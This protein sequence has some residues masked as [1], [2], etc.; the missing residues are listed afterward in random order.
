M[1]SSLVSIL[2]RFKVFAENPLPPPLPP[3]AETAFIDR[4][5]PPLAKM[6]PR[7]LRINVNQKAPT[8]LLCLN[9]V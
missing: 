6:Y 7:G 5:A 8:Y 9:I 3:E 1:L 4:R 2:P